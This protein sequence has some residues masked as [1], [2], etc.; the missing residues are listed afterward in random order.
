MLIKFLKH[1]IGDPAKAASYVVDDKDHLNRPRAGVEV[2]R[3]DPQTFSALATS[4]PHKYRYTSAVIAWAPEDLPSSK[5]IQEVL[6]AFE[7]HA[8]AGLKPNQYHMTAV[9]HIEDNGAKHVHILVP[10]I[11]LETGKSLNIAPPGHLNYFDALRDYFNHSKN[12]ARPDDPKRAK[13]SKL[14]NHLHLQSAAALRA[15]FAGKSK[16]HRINMIEKYVTCRIEHG[17]IRDR[18]SMLEALREIGQITRTGEKYISLKTEGNPPDRLKGLI[19]SEQFTI[20]DFSNDRNGETADRR[21]TATAESIS[22]EHRKIAQPD[23]N[24]IEALRNKR[25]EYNRNTYAKPGRSCE[26]FRIS[27]EAELSSRPNIAQSSA[28]D[29]PVASRAGNREKRNDLSEKPTGARAE[30]TATADRRY[31]VPNNSKFGANQPAATFHEKFAVFS[32]EFYC[33]G[34]AFNHIHPGEING[35]Y[36]IRS[37]K[38]TTD[39][40]VA[41]RDFESEKANERAAEYRRII[42]QNNQLAAKL[43]RKIDHADLAIRERIA[44]QKR[45]DQLV[46]DRIVERDTRSRLERFYAELKANFTKAA[47]RALDFIGYRKSGEQPSTGSPPA[48]FSESITAGINRLAGF[49]KTRRNDRSYASKC[50]AECQ[51]LASGFDG[52]GQRIQKIKLS[53]K[54]FKFPE[55]SLSDHIHALQ[56]SVG[57]ASLYQA[58]KSAQTADHH[59]KY[60]FTEIKNISWT[61][62]KQPVI[63]IEYPHW[64]QNCAGEIQ[65]NLNELK[66]EDYVHVYGFIDTVNKYEEMMNLSHPDFYLNNHHHLIKEKVNEILDDLKLNTQQMEFKKGFTWSTELEEKFGYAVPA[67]KPVPRPSKSDSTP[68][69]DL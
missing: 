53:I 47:E 27:I 22:A 39:S 30:K 37:I 44:E 68:S 65:N 38:T 33:F 11:E 25:A 31:K 20:Q 2:L 21:A 4:S 56:Q 50:A 5:D 24:D 61:Q 42:E 55:K 34:L 1:G 58:E 10:R 66:K 69:L 8:F 45:I 29:Q 60:A 63:S 7:Q 40:V 51:R 13:V 15:G 6:D 26:K 57:V 54:R 41:V 62:D 46:S 48:T 16:V 35:Q 12:W 59:L 49:E 18:K 67:S 19:Y 17:F 36:R 14:P 9:M 23:L 43:S 64:I 52:F 28:R 32:Y 3:G